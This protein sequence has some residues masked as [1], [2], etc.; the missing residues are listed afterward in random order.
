MHVA[1]S[2][3]GKEVSRSSGGNVW[4]SAKLERRGEGRRSRSAVK[5]V[6]GKIRSNERQSENG[7]GEGG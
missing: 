4:V 5:S 1:M 6:G 3:P 2:E 7:K